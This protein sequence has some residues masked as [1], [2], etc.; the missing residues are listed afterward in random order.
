M[1]SLPAKWL[2]ASCLRF[3]LR[4]LLL[5]VTL[6]AV[7]V[8]TWLMPSPPVRK[9]AGGTTIQAS[10][11]S[12]AV[13]D[14]AYRVRDPHGRLRCVGTMKKGVPT[15]RWSVYHPNGRLALTGTLNDWWRFG[16]WQAWDERGRQQAVFR[17]AVLGQDEWPAE[18]RY[19]PSDGGP[20]RLAEFRAGT[21]IL[22]SAAGR[23][24][25]KGEFR[26][27]DR[28]GPWTIVDHAGTVHEQDYD[29]GHAAQPAAR[30]RLAE[31]RSRL[32]AERDATAAPPGDDFLAAVADAERSGTAGVSWL[33]ETL[34]PR[35]IR[36]SRIVLRALTRL[37][38]RARGA[39]P[40][41]AAFERTAKGGLL[42]E[43]R[44][45]EI[46]I[47][48]QEA[49]RKFE[50]IVDDLLAASPA[51]QSDQVLQ[52]G[53]VGT[54]LVPHLER[55][56]RRADDDRWLLALMLLERITAEADRQFADNL[57]SAIGESLELAAKD[58]RP[59]VAAIADR[60]L[61][62]IAVPTGGIF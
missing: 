9:L 32:R 7:A 16:T 29:S 62:A 37:G 20:E 19:M 18:K 25:A 36:R 49:D 60:I 40:A 5:A 31:V 15:G 4:T 61:K 43:A 17:F 24:I 52:L 48:A 11:F 2:P 57:R 35:D 30:A 26:N 59:E 46:A 12:E 1:A 54:C 39:L 27:G 13:P 33:S 42:F 55:L 22:W 53:A 3:R 51:A 8:R 56:F 47:G 21:T 50:A 6:A 58:E 34:D 41:L 38:G 28:H 14:G 45:A 44:L 23:V 10:R